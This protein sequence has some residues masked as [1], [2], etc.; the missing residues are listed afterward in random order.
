MVKGSICCCTFLSW[1]KESF[2]WFNKFLFTLL[3]YFVCRCI[4]ESVKI[5]VIILFHSLHKLRFYRTTWYWCKRTIR[6]NTLSGIPLWRSK[7]IVLFIIII[8][9]RFVS[10]KQISCDVIEFLLRNFCRYYARLDRHI[11]AFLRIKNN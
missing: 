7:Y 5:F 1:I 6:K 8:Q 3:I 11:F 4:K 2:S 10:P 9:H